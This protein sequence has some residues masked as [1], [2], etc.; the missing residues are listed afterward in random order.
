MLRFVVVASETQTTSDP[1][2]DTRVGGG[3]G[4][5]CKQTPTDC[6]H[7]LDRTTSKLLLLGSKELQN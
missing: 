6:H 1:N 3:G 4:V 5:W 2:M 7:N